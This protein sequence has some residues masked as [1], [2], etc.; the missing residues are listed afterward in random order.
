MS[1]LEVNTINPQS[2]TTIT[3]GGS[4]DTVTL[5]SGA[6]QSGFGGV[7]TPNFGVYGNGTSVSNGAWTKIAFQNEVYDTD[8]AFDNSSNYRFTVPSGKGGKYFF[9][10]VITPDNGVT[11][12]DWRVQLYKNGSAGGLADGFFSFL[13]DTKNVSGD[14]PT[15]T[16][17][18]VVNLNAGD[19]IE[20]YGY[21]TSGASRTFNWPF[22]QGFRLVE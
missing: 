19:Y 21:H 2:G 12:T 7:N 13:S 3:I 10:L 15:I 16:G 11:F 14:F 8:S 1:T 6:T 22:F 18:C 5:G 17:S 9:N 4:G 20:V